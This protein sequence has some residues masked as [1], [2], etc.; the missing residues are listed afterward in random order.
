M[1]LPKLDTAS[2]AP[3]PPP[4]LLERLKSLD[5]KLNPYGPV[6]ERLFIFILCTSA[7]AFAIVAVVTALLYGTG[8]ALFIL[9]QGAKMAMS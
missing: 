9:V 2:L 3:R 4:T 7:G 6:L 5:S 1:G 8:F